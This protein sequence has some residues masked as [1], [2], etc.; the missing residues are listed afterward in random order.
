MVPL[1]S[2][3]LTAALPVFAGVAWARRYWGLFGRLLFTFVT[4]VAALFVWFLALE[5]LGFRY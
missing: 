1:V 2:T 3:A 4:L 5:P